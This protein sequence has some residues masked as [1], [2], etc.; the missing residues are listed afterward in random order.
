LSRLQHS[1][2]AWFNYQCRYC[3][4]LIRTEAGKTDTAAERFYTISEVARVLE[5]SDQSI[6]RW[7]KA[8]ELRAFKPKKE[9]RIAESD[10][11]EFL[12]ERRVPLVQARLLDFGE[13]QHGAEDAPHVEPRINQLT[14]AAAQ[15]ER[16]TDQ[17][18]Y[19]LEKLNVED[20]QA[21][22]AVSLGMVINHAEDVRELKQ[23]CTTGQLERLEQAEKRYFD[24][25][26]QFWARVEDTLARQSVPNLAER[27]A[28]LQARRTEVE[29]LADLA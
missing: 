23:A 22:D 12:K 13:E 29:R 21:I 19:N 1:I 27:R 24:A 5:V 25:N 15:W 6:R 3:S 7:V 8:G 14:S 28:E 9:Y 17:E 20:L 11:Q 26:L 10:L 4:T 18:L 2:A 16:F